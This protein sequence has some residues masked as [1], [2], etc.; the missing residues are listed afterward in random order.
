MKLLFTISPFHDNKKNNK[1]NYFAIEFYEEI[2]LFVFFDCSVLTEKVNL[3]SK[4]WPTV[5]KLF[6]PSAIAA[7]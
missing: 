7:F 3:F 5:V 4:F 1:I 2:C 6:F